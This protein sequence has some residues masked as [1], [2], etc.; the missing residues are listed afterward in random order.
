MTGLA[1]RIANATLKARYLAVHPYAALYADFGDFSL[2]RLRPLSGLY[3][4][5]FARAARLRAVDLAPEP[6]AVAA[7]EAAAED[8]M[9]HC[10]ADHPDALAAIARAPGDWRMVGVDV[11][12]CDLAQDEQVVR[13][14]WAAP[15]SDT[16]GVR[17]ELVRLAHAARA[18]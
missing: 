17:R 9:A 6:A 18:D 2:W 1:E 8:I 16:H 11:D 14:A 3:V 13:I 5:G 10:N 15:V 7:I 4:G 12:G